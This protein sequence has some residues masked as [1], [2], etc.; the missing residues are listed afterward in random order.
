MPKHIF[1]A[2]ETLYLCSMGKRF[3]VTA[4]FTDDAEANEHMRKHDNQACIAA[5]GPLVILAD[6]YAGEPYRIGVK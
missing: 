3:R 2:D 5:F 6:K 4:I 1:K